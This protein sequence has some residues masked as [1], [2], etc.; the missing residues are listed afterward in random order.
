MRPSGVGSPVRAAR[1]PLTRPR[2]VAAALRILEREG[3]AGLSMRKLADELGKA[4]AAVYRHVS[5]KRELMGL[6]FDEVSRRIV[7]PES[8]DEPRALILAAAQNAHR[9]LEEHG[10]VAAGMLD[11]ALVGATSLRLSEFVLDTLVRH[12]MSDEAAARLHLAIWQYLI[13][14]L[15]AGAPRV[16]GPETGDAEP[17]RYPTVH[18]V[19]PLI[20]RMSDQERFT[21][22]LRVLLD[23][24]FA[25]A[26]PVTRSAGAAPA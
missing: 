5:D 10:W 13:G 6:L 23:G 3:T 7:I 26:P 21:A 15:V 18:R 12:G 11:G 2:I 8:D 24:A 20:E 16:I 9:T 22:G 4:P 14:H 1:Q 19:A 17:G 25:P